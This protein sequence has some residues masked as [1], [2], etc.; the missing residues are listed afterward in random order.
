M[1]SREEIDATILLARRRAE[2]AGLQGV[3]WWVLESLIAH[4]WACHRVAT[5]N[6]IAALWDRVS[7]AGE[8]VGKLI[9]SKWLTA[10]LVDGHPA[11]GTLTEHAAHTLGLRLCYPP[12]ESEGDDPYWA[13]A[14]APP[15]PCFVERDWGGRK[16]SLT[17]WDRLS[18]TLS[19]GFQPDLYEVAE[20][21]P[22]AWLKM[23]KERARRRA[24]AARGKQPARR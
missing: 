3:R 21:D 14:E 15:L 10:W 13:I 11:Y 2:A 12:Y 20:M 18:L 6:R 19:Y 4:H 9:E 5:L 1:R 16:R 22:R 23:N 24:A 8:V 17:P 7:P